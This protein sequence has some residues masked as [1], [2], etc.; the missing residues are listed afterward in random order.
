VSRSL[1]VA[2][3]P[4]ALLTIVVVSAH[5][6]AALCVLAVLPGVPGASGAL[7]VLALGAA[8]AWRRALLRA[9]S[10]ITALEIDRAGVQIELK[11]GARLQAA[12][13]ERR[14]V[15]RHL[16]LLPLRA[17]GRRTLLVTRD[18]TDAESFRRLRIWA[19]W[20]RLSGVA[21]KQLAA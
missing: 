4:S 14:Y 13:A 21:G 5:A 11:S 15:G 6:V 9:P 10:S 20:G 18:M 19:L 17:P 12:V 16:V 1:R 7:V 3:A 2:L 8:S